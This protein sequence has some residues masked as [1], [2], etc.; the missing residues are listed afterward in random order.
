MIPCREQYQNLSEIATSGTSEA[1]DVRN[2]SE[3]IGSAVAY[4]Q[5]T[6]R[7]SSSNERACCLRFNHL[8]QLFR[9]HWKPAIRHVLFNKIG[10]RI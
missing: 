6:R 9:S 8:T 4:G 5:E 10:F 1:S 3:R 2:A 7:N